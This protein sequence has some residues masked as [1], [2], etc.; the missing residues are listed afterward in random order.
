MWERIEF[1]NLPSDLMKLESKINEDF[2]DYCPSLEQ[3]AKFSNNVIF[4]IEGLSIGNIKH[5]VWKEY[6]NKK[7]INSKQ[8]DVFSNFLKIFYQTLW[9]PYNLLRSVELRKELETSM[10]V[11]VHETSQIIPIII[12]ALKKRI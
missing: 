10:R 1:H 9:E 5:L 12:N 6:P 7:D 2:Y 4:R 3:I 11:S 8:F